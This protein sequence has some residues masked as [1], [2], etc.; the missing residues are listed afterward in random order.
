MDVLNEF[1]K[2]S[3]DNNKKLSLEINLGKNLFS[4][5][6][7][8]RIS[9]DFFF[10]KID[11]IKNNEKVKEIKKNIYYEYF[12][13]DLI[14]HVFSDGS[15]FCYKN[16]CIK[17][18]KHNINDESILVYELMEIENLPN[19]LFPSIKDY[20]LEK[21]NDSISI[22]FDGFIINFIL[23][24]DLEKYYQIKIIVNNNLKNKSELMEI[25]NLL[26]N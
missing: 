12:L 23:C 3:K 16:K 6:V 4:S 24:N 21:K 19:D 10:N 25:I 14:L 8:F 2:K 5:C 15:S 1:V 9:E 18:E 17:E 7:D 11:L 22:F 20:N 13:N 26:K